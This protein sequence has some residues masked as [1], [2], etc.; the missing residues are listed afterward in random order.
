MVGL[1][2][3]GLGLTSKA[4]WG[5]DLWV[6]VASLGA[7]AFGLLVTPYLTIYPLRRLAAWLKSQPAHVLVGGT[8]GL[9]IGLI[10]SALL[11]PPLSFLPKPA[12]MVLPL[13]AALMLSYLGAVVTASRG[14]EIWQSIN[15][16]LSRAP[17][18]TH[19]AT[20]NGRVILDT[21]TIIDGRIADVSQTGFIPGTLVIPR[22]VLD[23]LRHIADSPESTRRNRGRR[24]L[25]MLARLQ[26]ESRVPVNIA[27]ADAPD[28]VDTDA[29]LVRLARQ[30]HCPIITNDFNL[31]RVAELQGV[32][33]LNI[34]E[35][36]NAVK[37]IVLPGE[38]LSIRIIQEG[39]ETGQGVG[40]LDDGTMVV[41]EGGRRYLNT[42]MDILVTRVL[43]TAA[44]RML[45]ATP[46]SGV[47]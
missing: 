36:A 24:G 12:S 9:V 26:K 16:F 44:G 46:K 29:K 11:A 28:V 5:N 23:E 10:I 8:V 3:A 33:V 42:Q 7:A 14:P 22:F 6:L 21:S 32:R 4:N 34:N 15:S 19:R 30:W 37:T 38:E 39:K 35:L 45:F 18:E 27:D 41:V 20:S 31:N 17:A 43:Q 25:E 2:L 1:G 47:V 40:F 13:V